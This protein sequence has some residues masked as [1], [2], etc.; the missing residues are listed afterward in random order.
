MGAY[1]SFY[2][3]EECKE[4]ILTISRVN[5]L[6]VIIASAVNVGNYKLVNGEIVEN[7]HIFNSDDLAKCYD[8]LNEK[9]SNQEKLIGLQLIKRDYDE[10]DLLEEIEELYESVAI[11]GSLQILSELLFDNGNELYTLY[12]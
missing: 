12:G 10:V 6:S 1:L 9:I 2:K 11:R 5:G 8:Y 4:S 7:P 3:D